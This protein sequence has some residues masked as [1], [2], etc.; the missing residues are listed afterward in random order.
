M[1]TYVRDELYVLSE[2]VADARAAGR[3]VVALESS[4]VVHGLRFPLNLDT[5]RDMEKNI[6][7]AGAVP[8]RIGIVDGRLVVGMSDEQVETFATTPTVPKVGAR[9]IGPA[10]AAGGHGGTTVSAALV[11]A[12]AAGIEV[13]AVAGIGGAHFG[14]ARSLDISAD[15]IEFTR[16]RVA[17]VCAGAKSL[18]DPALTL[19]FL[20]TQ[21]VPVVGYR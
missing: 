16:H 14:A 4:G 8:A 15:L 5:A 17:V 18:I 1:P 11:G 3:P 20:E 13:L 9:D 12:A 19:E 2:E 21:G 10:L 7:A 6:R